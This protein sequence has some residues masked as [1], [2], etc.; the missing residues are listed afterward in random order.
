MTKRLSLKLTL[1]MGLLL[2]LAVFWAP[3][4]ARGISITSSTISEVSVT[5]SPSVTVTLG[6]SVTTASSTTTPGT[7]MTSTATS[8]MNTTASTESQT[9]VPVSLSF[10]ANA[11]QSAPGT[12]VPAGTTRQSPFSVFTVIAGISI[13]GLVLVKRN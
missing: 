12:P 8:A 3:V 1:V 13:A 5:A 9:T 2:V 10:P 11:Q 6:T 7:S 4:C